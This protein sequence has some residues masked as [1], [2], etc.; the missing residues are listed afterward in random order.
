MFSEPGFD[1]D[2]FMDSPP[3]SVPQLIEELGQNM[4]PE[5]VTQEEM[6]ILFRQEYERMLED[7]YR[8]SQ[9]DEDAEGFIG[10]EMPKE[11]LGEDDEED[12]FDF[13]LRR[14]SEYHPYPSKTAMLLDVMDNL[15][16]C[17]F[18][19]TQMSLLGVP[20]KLQSSCGSK[21]VKTQSHLGNIFYMNDIRDSIAR[22]MANPLVAPHMHFY[23]EEND[24]PI[25]ET[26]QAERWMEYTPSQLTPM[27]SRGFKRFWIEELA[28]LRDRT[29]VIPHTW[30]VRNGVLTSDVSIVTRTPD[31][32]WQHHSE[33]ERTVAADDLELDYSDLIAEFGANLT[34]VDDSTVPA[35]PN[36]MR[37]LVDDDEDLYVVMVSPWADDVSGNKS[38]QYNKHMNMYTGNGCLPGRL[39]QQE[40]NIHYISTSP[41]ASSAEQ[42]STFRDHVQSTEKEPIKCYN[43]VTK[44]RCRC[45]LRTPGLPADNPQQSEECCHMGSN[46]NFPCR[47]C[48]WGGTNREKESDTVFHECHLTG[49]AR[50]AREIRETLEEQ[51]RLSMLGDAK[52]VE[53][54]QRK[55]GTKDKVAQYWI[56]Q[57]ISKAKAMKSDHPRRKAD[58]IAAELK[59]W[60][61]AQP[62]DKMNPL[63]DLVGLD[64]SQD[65]PVELLHTILLGVVKYIWHI[66]NT[67]QWSDADRC[68]L[69]I[70]LQ[71]T[72]ISGLTVPPIRAG[73]MVQYKNNLIGKHFKTLMQ[74]LAFHIHH[75]STP[76]QFVLVKAAG[77]LGARLW[78][79]EIDNMED[80]LAQLKIAIANVL[81]AFDAVDPCRI[82]VKIKLHLLAHIPDDVRRFG[83]SIRFATEIYEAYNAVFSAFHDIS[84]KFAAMARVKHF[85]SGGYWWDSSTKQW[86][87][88]GNAVQQILIA[89]PVFQRHLGWV[90]PSIT[91]PGSIKPFSLQRRPALKWSQ[92]KTST[93]W[94][95]GTAPLPES[96]WRPGRVLTAQSGDEV[97]LNSWVIALDSGGNTVIGRVTE[98]LVAEKSLV[99]LEQFICGQERHP[100]FGWPVLR[101]PNGP[102]IV[103]RQVQSFVVLSA[104]AVQFVISVQ[105]DCREGDCQPTVVHKEFQEREETSRNVSLI[106]HSNDD[107]FVIN[108]AGLHNFPLFPD[109]VTFHKEAAEQARALRAKGRAKT[110]ERRR[111]KA[112]EKKREAELAAAAARQAEEALVTGEEIEQSD[113]EPNAA[114]GVRVVYEM[115]KKSYG[116]LAKTR[117]EKPD[118]AKIFGRPKVQP[119]IEMKMTLES[120]PRET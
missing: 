86:I 77:E 84:R 32:R 74:A 72:D 90:S 95:S 82:L 48:K 112:A 19:S 7:A 99:T 16:R 18:T 61:D 36:E 47:K 12:C 6:Q 100:D 23:P 106:K 14:S 113:E 2:I 37:K 55:S 87:Q 116:T 98:L 40:F 66:L 67:S 102:E 75:I 10:D 28:C 89:D 97:A 118:S 1:S 64:P 94:T 26:Y 21:P 42:F 39:L 91:D 46:A 43:A 65:T 68:L 50:N 9:M 92:T 104:A 73:Y 62:G 53:D 27:F 93:H 25:S 3:S 76:E 108:M 51:L 17:R 110:A 34:W 103:Q 71:S 109:R 83:P 85:L 59:T 52:A 33:V 119:K 80:Y 31:E 22:D 30:I 117:S 58:E 20:D 79:P 29:F 111:A 35:M 8:E 101:R 41:H 120:N 38:K 54:N 11:D 63:L 13:S 49:V 45:I 96:W 70:R 88:A 4:R 24:G 69:A 15:P 44:R 107:H 5:P 114:S 115:D 60:F 105:H 57:L 81:D 56:E 78:V